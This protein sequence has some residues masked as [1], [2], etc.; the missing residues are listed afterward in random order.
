MRAGRYRM[1]GFAEKAYPDARDLVFDLGFRFAVFVV[2][3]VFALAATFVRGL[4]AGLGSAL[5]L[6]AK[7]GFRY[8]PV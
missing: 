7:T 3:R 1:S 2:V 5:R 8:W 6:L 4:A